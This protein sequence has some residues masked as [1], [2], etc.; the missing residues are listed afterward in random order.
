[1]NAQIFELSKLI[2]DNQVKSYQIQKQLDNNTEWQNYL[3]DKINV[4]MAKMAPEL[5]GSHPRMKKD[6][7]SF[8]DEINNEYERGGPFIMPQYNFYD[9]SNSNRYYDYL[10]IEKKTENSENQI[11]ANVENFEREEI[12]VDR[13]LDNGSPNGIEMKT[14]FYPYDGGDYEFYDFSVRE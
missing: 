3:L 2:L 7:A 1:M 4:E 12:Q 14:S 13:M 5:G 8:D 9:E 10:E 11:N 6:S